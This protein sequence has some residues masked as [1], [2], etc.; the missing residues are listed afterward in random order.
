MDNKINNN[1]DNQ[2]FGVFTSGFRWSGSSAVSDWLESFSSIRKPEGCESAY[3]EIR[4]LNYGLTIF[5]KIIMRKYYVGEQLAKYSMC[6]EKCEWKRFFGE[7]LYKSKGCYAPL[8]AAADSFFMTAAASRLTPGLDKYS[9]MLEK[10]LGSSF[11]EDKEYNAVVLNF[12]NAVRY[13][14]EQKY[15]TWDE[16]SG[17]KNLVSAVSAF[18]SFFYDR[19]I[20]RGYVP[21]IDN[22]I[23]GLNP[24]F[25][26]LVSPDYFR[27]KIIIFVVRDPRD[28]FAEQVKFS[29]KTFS[30]MAK[31]FV[32]D[33]RKK[34]NKTSEFVSSMKNTKDSD[35][36]MLSF[37]DFVS[38]KNSTRDN[39]ESSISRHLES[40]N[41][42]TDFDK[43]SYSAE[44]SSKNIGVW[45]NS[46]MNKEMDFISRELKSFLKEQAD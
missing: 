41:L 25:F 36:Y 35:V 38:N 3:D 6:P 18:I 26:D 9:P 33:Y 4:A 28:Q 42:K 32:S 24:H 23:S 40:F 45:K 14:S 12:T 8:I 7:P 20:S 43:T 1:N 13:A 46:G 21:V 29:A 34:Y 30:F 31:H 5:L 27:K 11:K 10:Q 17:D 44:Y 2:R 15:S 37:E 39:L 19:Y 22:A 16:V